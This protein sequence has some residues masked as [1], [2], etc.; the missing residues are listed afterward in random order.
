MHRR[1][2]DSNGKPLGLSPMQE[3]KIMTAEACAA[4]IVKAIENRDRLLITS[5]R[6]KLGRWMKMIVPGVIERLALKA[7][8]ERK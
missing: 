4:M 8:R 6:G 7:I 2:F 1:A 3:D 5:L